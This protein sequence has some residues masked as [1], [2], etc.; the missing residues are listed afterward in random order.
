MQRIGVVFV[1]LGCLAVSVFAFG[2]AADS[3]SAHRA[4]CH[5]QHECP[6]D[7]ATYR[8][9][10]K[11]LL[12]VKPTSVYR[13]ET[14]KMRVVHDGRLH[15]CKGAAATAIASSSPTTS[16]S[17][18]YK[19]TVTQVVDGDTLDVRIGSKTE[20]VR[21]I[22]IDA[23]ERGDCYAGS[24]TAAATHLA[25]GKRVVLRGDPTQATRDRYGRLLAYVVL[26]HGKDLGYQMIAG[27]FAKV[28]VYNRR[29]FQ[30][31]AAYRAAE[32]TG[33][34][35][36]HSVWRCGTTTAPVPLASSP[37]TRSNCDSSYP[38]VCIPPYEKV[39]DLDCADVPFTDIRVVGSDPHGFDG[40]DN[41]GVGCES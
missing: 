36:G 29:D 26:P 15:L 18:T 12:C 37:T 38:D 39:G 23:P 35:L 16:A 41:D 11:Q 33:R 3:A 5:Q 8:W 9:G 17:F 32:T 7:H 2:Y 14:F 4:Q 21:V 13:N 6:S 40:R 30:R 1:V 25:Y 28:Y 10:P 27:G 31:V 22:G 19:G 24:A 20:R 34:R